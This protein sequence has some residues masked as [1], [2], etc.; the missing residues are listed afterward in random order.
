[1]LFSAGKAPKFTS[2]LQPISIAVGDSCSIDIQVSG[3]PFPNV[4]WLKDKKQIIDT[5]VYKFMAGNEQCS[6]VIDK[7]ELDMS[8][9]YTV[10]ISNEH[11]SAE[12]SVSLQVVKGT[13][14]KYRIFCLLALQVISDLPNLKAQTYEII[15]R[16][17]SQIIR[18]LL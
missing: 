2:S 11:G 1:M 12:T 17:M 4:T 3:Y 7:A 8:G 18:Q 5:S 9:L 6:L 13:K 15:Y 16:L 10:K 14:I